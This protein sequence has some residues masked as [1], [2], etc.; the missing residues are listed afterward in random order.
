MSRREDLLLGGRGQEELRLTA[1][2][3]DKLRKL[4]GRSLANFRAP[5]DRQQMQVRRRFSVAPPVEPEREITHRGEH[6]ADAP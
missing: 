4:F 5:I 2:L 1:A 6:G 3:D